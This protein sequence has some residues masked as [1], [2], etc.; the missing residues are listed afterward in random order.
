LFSRITYIFVETK[1]NKMNHTAKKSVKQ[2]YKVTPLVSETLNYLYDS[3]TTDSLELS[4][5]LECRIYEKFDQFTNLE[6][7]SYRIV[8][9]KIDEHFKNWQ[10]N[11]L[12]TWE[13]K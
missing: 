9:N 7:E 1:I 6:L 13:S 4:H 3:I 10:N 2:H 12:P 11:E 8:A 5:Q